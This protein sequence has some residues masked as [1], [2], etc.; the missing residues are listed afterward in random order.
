MT[1]NSMPSPTLGK[2]PPHLARH[3]YEIRRGDIEQQ[4]VTVTPWHAL[5]EWERS[6]VEKEVDGFRRAVRQAEEEQLLDERDA[7]MADASPHVD[8]SAA[9]S[10]PGPQAPA[11]TCPCPFHTLLSA[12]EKLTE[13][14]AEPQQP[15]PGKIGIDWG[16]F[17]LG[18][19]VVVEIGPSPVRPSP[20]SVFPL[21][22]R[23]WGIPLTQEEQARLENT[24]PPKTLGM[25]LFTAG[26]DFGVLTSR[27]PRGSYIDVPPPA[28]A[29][30]SQ[31]YERFRK[32]LEKW[33]ATG[34][35][36]TVRPEPAGAGQGL[37]QWY[38]EMATEDGDGEGTWTL[39]LSLAAPPIRMDEITQEVIAGKTY[40]ALRR[41]AFLAKMWPAKSPKLSDLPKP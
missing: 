9:E 8:Y 14:P 31:A 6:L 38:E 19:T 36:I 27:A 13:Q 33:A 20:F 25:V 34:K 23:R 39:E 15:A 22:F 2:L 5:P 21:D 16:S 41:E 26:V 3:Y 10:V 12:I 11:E 7:L 35:P 40:E 37:L 32:E 24:A 29:S 28:A 4:G 1:T 17:T 18:P 30:Y